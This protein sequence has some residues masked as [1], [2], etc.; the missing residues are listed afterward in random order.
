MKK[1]AVTFIIK[2]KRKETSSNNV[3]V[4]NFRQQMAIWTD[5]YSVF[6]VWVKLIHI[7]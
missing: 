4:S 6:V 7:F 3:S 1:M 2:I 5:N